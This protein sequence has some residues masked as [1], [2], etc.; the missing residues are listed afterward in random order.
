MFDRFIEKVLP[1]KP[2][3]TTTL[4]YSIFWKAELGAYSSADITPNM[5]GQC[6]DKLLSKGLAPATVSRYLA[7]LSVV[8]TEAVKVWGW[9]EDTPMR[10]VKKPPLPRG[11]TRFLSD[12]ERTTLLQT[13]QQSRNK[14]LYT[15]VVTALS[16]GMRRGEQ[17][18]LRWA[19][20]NLKE[21]FLILRETK[22]GSSPGSVNRPMPATAKRT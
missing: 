22:N 2:K 1:S 21:G 6:R 13:C 9:L 4:N 19:D 17:M 15:A 3:D 16:T 10:N 20:V 8:Y 12:E 7:G 11:R 5:I 14:L 18:N